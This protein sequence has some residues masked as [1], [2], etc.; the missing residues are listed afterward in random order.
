MSWFVF[1]L[2]LAVTVVMLVVIVGP[3]FKRRGSLDEHA[4]IDVT[5]GQP[6]I[7]LFG[8]A[9]PFLI[10][11]AVFTYG[12]QAMSHM[13]VADGSATPEIEV[14]GHQW[15]WEIRYVGGPPPLHFVT[16]NEIHIPVGKPIDLKLSTADVIHSFW[17]PNLH[18]K[19]DMIPGNPNRIRLVAD[20]PGVFPGQ[21]GEYCGAQHAHM[22]LLVVADPPD[23][24]AQWL[25]HQRE[26][27]QQ[28]TTDLGRQGQDVFMNGA[29]P[30]CHKIR[31][32]LA[33]GGVAP[34]L[35]HMAS[36]L[37]LASNTLK[38][39]KANLAGW[40]THAQSLKPGVLMP[41]LATMN[42]RELQA[43]VAYLQQLD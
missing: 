1:L 15:W 22:R 18:G 24:Y 6:L 33:G 40:V 30:L 17:V 5:G 31:G 11:A 16:A 10:L 38:N 34:D 37:G 4:P 29:C 41:N 39:D 21:C 36:R 19:S 35:T 3:V 32:T 25:A 42:G 12:L 9:I 13:P 23:K 43:L 20:R 8:F 26:P 27:A 7:L 14:I 28:P 2:F